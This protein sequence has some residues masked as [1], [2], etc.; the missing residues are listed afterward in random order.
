MVIFCKLLF[1]LNYV[2]PE[3]TLCLDI[4]SSIDNIHS[5]VKLFKTHFSC[6]ILQK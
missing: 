4:E 5:V 1:I 6:V 2:L 3:E